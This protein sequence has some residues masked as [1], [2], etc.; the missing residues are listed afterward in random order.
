MR[1]LRG[2]G[3]RSRN[4]EPSDEH[5]PVERNVPTAG[6][7]DRETPSVRRRRIARRTYVLESHRDPNLGPDKQLADFRKLAAE[8]EHV[9]TLVDTS[10]RFIY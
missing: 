5:E 2:S 7:E 3:S 10:V 8:E 9:S 1:A 6:T 4:V